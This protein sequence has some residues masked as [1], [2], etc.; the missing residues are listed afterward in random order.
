M[1][2]NT[3]NVLVYLNTCIEAKD[4]TVRYNSGGNLVLTL[5]DTQ[6][7]VLSGEKITVK[8][9]NKY[10]SR[11]SDAGGQVKLAVPVMTPKTYTA[12]ISFSG[13]GIYKKS[14]ALVK[15]NVIKQLQN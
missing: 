1:Y 7:N 9:N 4:V 6:G 3:F 5:K 15:V 13:D 10:Y 12:E 8:L 2:S 11:L 14:N